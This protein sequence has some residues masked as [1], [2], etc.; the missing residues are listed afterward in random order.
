MLNEELIKNCIAKDRKAQR[1]LYEFC[2][3][4]LARV[5]FRYHDNE[6]DKQEIINESFIKVINNVDKISQLTQSVEAWIHRI[7]VN[8][9]IDLYRSSKKYNEHIKLNSSFVSEKER[10]VIIEEHFDENIDAKYIIQVLNEL[11]TVTKEVMN[12]FA[13]DG[14]SHKEIAEQLNISEELSRWH[15]H[16]GRKIIKEKLQYYSN[17]KKVMN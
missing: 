2:Y 15:V 11:P 3:P 5:A 9:A 8:T 14:F 7:G 10:D 17:S 12:L 4:I 16:K 1:E 13:I 6:E